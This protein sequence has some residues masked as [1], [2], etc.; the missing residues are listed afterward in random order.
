MMLVKM[1][2]ITHS[3][4]CWETGRLEI[5]SRLALSFFE[6]FTAINITDE[7]VADKFGSKCLSA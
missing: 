5:T 2:T 6:C 3:L 4:R 1:S 7:C